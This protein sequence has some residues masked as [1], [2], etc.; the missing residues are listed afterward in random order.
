M[1]DLSLSQNLL[2]GTIPSYIQ[3]RIW[4]TLELSYNQLSGTLNIDH[5]SHND[6]SS[7]S[8]SSSSINNID[9]D[10][11]SNASISLTNNRLS[12]RI[13]SY[14]QS[15]LKLSILEGNTFSC[16]FDRHE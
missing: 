15:L 10:S 7:S 8:D 3:N 1:N 16:S 4:K 5:F 12:G 11:R 9:S 13:P 2:I 6:D 14:F